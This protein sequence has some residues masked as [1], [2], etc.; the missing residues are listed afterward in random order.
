MQR[1]TAAA[2][3]SFYRLPALVPLALMMLGAAGPAW[4]QA[5]PGPL[6]Q[7]AGAPPE[8]H[9][10]AIRVRVNEV[11]APVTVT[12][13]A[14][15]MILDLSKDN[16]RVYDNGVRQKIEHFD[17]GGDPLSVVLAVETSSH[18]EPLLPA[19]RQT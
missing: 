6:H 14:G 15:Q 17:L 13:Q 4:C 19:V 11:V 18:I 2:R 3:G 1:I 12:N 8:Q 10:N 7:K 16:F 9:K 5:A